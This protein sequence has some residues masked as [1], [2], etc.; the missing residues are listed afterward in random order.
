[1]IGILIGFYL[2]SIAVIGEFQDDNLGV[3]EDED[4]GFCL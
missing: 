4:S 1:M 3:V 2:L